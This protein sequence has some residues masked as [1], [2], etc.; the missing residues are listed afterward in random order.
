MSS[1]FVCCASSTFRRALT[2]MSEQSTFHFSRGK[3]MWGL[4][5]KHLSSIKC[6]F[7]LPEFPWLPCSMIFVALFSEILGLECWECF[8]CLLPLAGSLCGSQD[9]D[10]SLTKE[11]TLT[12]PL[13]LY[14]LPRQPFQH[15]HEPYSLHIW[16]RQA[17]KPC[18]TLEPLSLWS[19]ALLQTHVLARFD[20]MHQGFSC[21]YN[22]VWRCAQLMKYLFTIIYYCTFLVVGGQLSDH[23]WFN[24]WFHNF[25][26]HL[27]LRTEMGWWSRSQ[28]GKE[29]ECLSLN[30]D[31]G[32]LMSPKPSWRCSGR[33]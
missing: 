4:V 21:H 31:D 8:W 10:N 18:W 19:L 3:S 23:Q 33:L 27:Q 1:F 30:S 5:S 12:T 7:V 2:W 26:W 24:D 11:D 14:R 15:T 6:Y 9:N 17:V 22:R 20:L 25:A 16:S 28:R 13:C 29:S 32:H